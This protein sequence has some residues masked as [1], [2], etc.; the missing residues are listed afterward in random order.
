MAAEMK[1]GP[2]AGRRRRPNNITVRAWVPPTTDGNYETTNFSHPPLVLAL[3]RS[4]SGSDNG[5]AGWLLA[6]VPACGFL[7]CHCAIGWF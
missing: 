4:P 3:N 7:R 1:H 5:N 6:H 2:M